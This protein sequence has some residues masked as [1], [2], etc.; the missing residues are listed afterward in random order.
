M[1]R[2]LAHARL[3]GETGTQHIL[4]SMANNMPLTSARGKGSCCGAMER[5]LIKPAGS[6]FDPPPREMG[7]DAFVAKFG[8]IYEHSPWIA[9][10]VH[11]RGLNAAHDRPE[12]LARAMAEV[13]ATAEEPAKLDLI[14]RHP[15][16]AGRAAVAGDL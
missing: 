2:Q 3:R 4:Y 11:A 1:R 15:D 13:L 7:R 16:L 6:T 12:G 9:E 14:R 5:C 10:A 8:S